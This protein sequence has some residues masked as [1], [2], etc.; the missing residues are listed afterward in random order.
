[1]RRAIRWLILALAV[2]EAGGCVMFGPRCAT[3][4]VQ[5]NWA[6]GRVTQMPMTVCGYDWHVG[7]SPLQPGA[8]VSED[9]DTSRSASLRRQLSRAQRV[10]KERL[11]RLVA[12]LRE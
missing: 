10:V 1:M 2:V 11:S 4:S 12:K 5:M 8:D 3:R 7:R 6:D 9:N